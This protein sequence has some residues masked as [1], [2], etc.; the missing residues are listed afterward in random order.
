MK[1]KLGLDRGKVAHARELARGV[2]RRVREH[3]A[4]FSTVST[5]RTVLRLLGLAGVDRRGVPLPNVVV[6][7]LAEAGQLAGG[8]APALRRLLPATDG[9]LGELARRLAAGKLRV[10]PGKGKPKENLVLGGKQLEALVEAG[11]A[12]LRGTA[13]ERR[14]RLASY[15]PDETPLIYCIVATGNIF[16]D[17]PQAEAAARQ[18]AQIIAV[19][20]STAQSLLDYVPEGATTKGFGGTFATQEN[21]RLMREACDRVGDELGRYVRV[22][23]YC[24]GLC[25]PE[26]AAMGAFE[27]LDV[28]LNDA[29]YG[30]LF[31]DI[32]MHR[33]L[34]DQHF[35]RMINGAAG[36]VINTGEDNYLKT[37]DAYRE[38]HTVL[39]SQL[40]NEA[41]AAM[42]GVPPEQM[43][44]GHAFEMDPGIASGFLYEVAQAQLSREVFP[45]AP[46]K[47]MPPTK[48][49]TGDIFKGHAQNA[50]FNLASVM[51]GQSIHL[52]GVLTEAIHTPYMQDRYLSVD[53]MRYIRNNAAGLAD[54]VEFAPGGKIQ[55]RARQVLDDAI[56]LLERIAA[57]GLF[58][59]LSQGVFGAVRRAQDGGK[60]AEGVFER[61][62]G[63]VNPFEDAILGAAPESPGIVGRTNST[64]VEMVVEQEG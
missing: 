3:H 64:P 61:G 1:S 62:P 53:A 59:A 49:M 14:R 51:T 43:G 56:A 52:V 42:A 31:R 60:G 55:Q 50:L 23:N 46:L 45:G 63:Y 15:A 19:I 29:L 28:M 40:I 27:R 12:R 21:M 6:E 39:S 13:G 41:F 5:E 37:A 36:I 22:C 25:M 44:L 16:D 32:N 9:D 24:S 10:L 47:Y 2:A 17:V 58:E 18:G 34:V 4:R 20:R 30:I 26:I 8:V 48:F 33:T 38:A 11:V 57:L 54:E 7:K 35:S